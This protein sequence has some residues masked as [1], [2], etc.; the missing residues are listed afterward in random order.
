M[1]PFFH[2]HI[3]PAVNNIYVVINMQTMNIDAI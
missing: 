3:T 2:M 1:F